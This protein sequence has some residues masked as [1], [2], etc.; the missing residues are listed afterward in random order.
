MTWLLA[1]FFLLFAQTCYKQKG[2]PDVYSKPIYDDPLHAHY[3]SPP[4]PCLFY[5]MSPFFTPPFLSSL[6]YRAKQL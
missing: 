2:V 6:L 5:T 1:A 3:P 4:V